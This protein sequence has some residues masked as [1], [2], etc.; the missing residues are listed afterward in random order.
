MPRQLLADVRPL[1]TGDNATLPERAPV[2]GQR[3]TTACYRWSAAKLGRLLRR[4]PLS[5][6]WTAVTAV[7]AP[8]A[9]GVINEQF[10]A[11]KPVWA[12]RSLPG[13]GVEGR[14]GGAEYLST[15]LQD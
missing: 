10:Y 14:L 1:R 7:L 4:N 11:T 8:L 13:A 3:E 15:C 5:E 12:N 2:G 6:G 9:L